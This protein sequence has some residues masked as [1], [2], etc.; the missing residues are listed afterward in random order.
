MNKFLDS[1][2]LAL[3]EDTTEQLESKFKTGDK[4]KVGKDCG[5]VE[6]VVQMKLSKT[7]TYKIRLDNGEEVDR[8]E[9]EL[10]LC[11]SDEEVPS[12]NI[13]DTEGKD[14]FTSMLQQSI[15]EEYEA[16]AN[17]VKRAAKCEE[18]GMEDA[19]KLFKDIAAEEMVHVGE[20]Q[21]LMEKYGV[22]SSSP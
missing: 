20:F 15:A 22:A 6:K 5:T 10:S 7:P 3:S 1:L 4:V 14:K 18:H 2:K 21:A 17:Y 16:S 8:Y 19:A 11:E 9:E 12:E 13:E